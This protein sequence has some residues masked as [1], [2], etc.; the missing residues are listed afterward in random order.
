MPTDRQ[1][2][3][4][5][6]ILNSTPRTLLNGEVINNSDN[7]PIIDSRLRPQWRETYDE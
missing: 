4:Q 5:T 3:R 7:K 6:D 1:T 2:D